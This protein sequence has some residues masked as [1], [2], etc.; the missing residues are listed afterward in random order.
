LCVFEEKID[1]KKRKNIKKNN[2]NKCWHHSTKKIVNRLGTR[3]TQKQKQYAKVKMASYIYKIIVRR[4][5]P[6]PNLARR[7]RS[8]VTPDEKKGN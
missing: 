6:S 5:F 4:S 3:E 2:Y 8:Q 1:Y 7:V